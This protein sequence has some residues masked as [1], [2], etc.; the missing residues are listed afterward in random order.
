M[1]AEPILIQQTRE[2]I[3]ERSKLLRAVA[4]ET[5]A[6]AQELRAEVEYALAEMA[7]LRQAFDARLKHARP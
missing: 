5:R 6:C 1:L 7:A 2:A 3:I 4:Q